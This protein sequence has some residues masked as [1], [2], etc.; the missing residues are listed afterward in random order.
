MSSSRHLLYLQV[1]SSRC[2][3]EAIRGTLCRTGDDLQAHVEGLKR[4]Q[5]RTAEELDALLPAVLE[6][7]FRGEL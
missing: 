7:A 2:N 1:P 6:R 5:A 3:D 4:C